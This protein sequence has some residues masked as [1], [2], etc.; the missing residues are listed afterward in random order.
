LATK[1]SSNDKYVT[2]SD[3][4]S[5][6][7]PSVALLGPFNLNSYAPFSSADSRHSTRQQWVPLGSYGSNFA[8][9]APVLVSFCLLSPPGEPFVKVNVFREVGDNFHDLEN[10]REVTDP[11]LRF[12]P[13]VVQTL[14]FMTENI[15]EFLILDSLLFFSSESALFLR[16]CAKHI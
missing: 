4:V 2:W 3:I 9:S 12:V 14:E 6:A 10:V 8:P 5:L 7:D 16:A 13:E 1:S 15:E 11:T